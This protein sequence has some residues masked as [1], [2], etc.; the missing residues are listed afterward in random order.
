MAA[1][2]W[3]S[4]IFHGENFPK[5][6]DDD[7]RVF[8]SIAGG[9]KSM[10]AMLHSVMG[11]LARSDDKIL[12]I[13]VSPPWDRIGG[14]LYPTCPGDFFDPT[15]KKIGFKKRPADALGNSIRI[16]GE[17]FRPRWGAQADFL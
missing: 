6:S 9:R 3:P 5:T 17:I 15:T 7:N 4:R 13:L 8:A 14:F 11:L 16:D 10:G 1:T 2:I 12:H